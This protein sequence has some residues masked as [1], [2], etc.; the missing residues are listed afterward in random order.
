MGIGLRLR[1]RCK[2]QVS[3]PRTEQEAEAVS[4]FHIEAGKGGG[5]VARWVGLSHCR[6]TLAQRGTGSVRA[7]AIHF[8]LFGDGD[9]K[10]FLRLAAGFFIEAR[11][12]F[13]AGEF[14]LDVG[15]REVA[16][17]EHDQEVI[18]RVGGL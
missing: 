1:Y 13:A 11:G 18:E 8:L 16:G 2:A 7:G 9:I 6:W 10:G 17:G 15:Q 14:S 4:E 3:R 5:D 12:A